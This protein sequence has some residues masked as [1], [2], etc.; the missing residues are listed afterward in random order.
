[1]DMLDFKNPISVAA[2]VL[3]ESDQGPLSLG[4]I[5]PLLLVGSS[6]TQWVETMGFSTLERI[7]PLATTTTDGTVV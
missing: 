2:K 7:R 1:M 3:Q 5:P 4:R 6:I